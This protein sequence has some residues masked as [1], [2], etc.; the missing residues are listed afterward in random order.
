MAAPNIVNV[1]TITGVTTYIA[2]IATGAGG[3][4]VRSGLST[5][6]SNASGSGKVLKI[7]NIS[8][9]CIGSTTG[10]TIR[11]HDSAVATTGVNTVSIAHT[12]FVPTF[13]TLVVIGK[14]NP[15]YLEENKVLTGIAQSNTGGRIDI[16]CSYE[17]IS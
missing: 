4:L 12:V 3:D 1:S 16:I 5:I 6:V 17:E 8:A 13:S 14:D 9:T 11:Y 7:N 2:G 15:I 10:V